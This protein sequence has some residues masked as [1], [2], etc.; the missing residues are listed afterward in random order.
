MSD[1]VVGVLVG[2]FVTLLVVAIPA[3]QHCRQ[4][5]REL[6]RMFL[7]LESLGKELERQG[8]ETRSLHDSQEKVLRAIKPSSRTMW[9]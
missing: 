5:R 9:D 1:A 8:C 2:A 3:V 6:V 4:Q 7:I